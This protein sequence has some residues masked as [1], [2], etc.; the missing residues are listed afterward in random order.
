MRALEV[1]A[2]VPLGARLTRA[3]CARKYSAAESVR[4][5]PPD[6]SAR[7]RAGRCI[8]C[9]VGEQ[10]EAGE[11]ATRWADGSP[12]VVAELGAVLAI[13]EKHSPSGIV[14]PVLPGSRLGEEKKDMAR[15]YSWGGRELTW[16]Q[17]AREPEVAKLGLSRQTLRARHVNKWTIAEALTTPKGEKPA[18]LLERRAAT[19]PQ[20]PKAAKPRAQSAGGEAAR[21]S[22]SSK[23]AA[24]ATAVREVLAA[25]DPLD[26]LRR[27]GFDVED[28]GRAPAGRL[29]VV[30]DAQ[31]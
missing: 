20:P 7:L 27:V 18:R 21:R 22:S 14:P 24:P 26:L 28:L 6:S 12:V 11:A 25:F 4:R 17:W 9:S 10:H 8:G 16:E 3:S 31:G 5:Q 1:F 15:K 19:A 23:D 29:F 13:S 2:C 30:R